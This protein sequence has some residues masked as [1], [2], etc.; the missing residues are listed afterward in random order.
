MKCWVEKLQKV[1]VEG[2]QQKEYNSG[3][4]IG[5]IYRVLMKRIES[6]GAKLAYRRKVKGWIFHRRNYYEEDALE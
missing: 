4:E 6:W 5:Q 2:T 1:C 3:N